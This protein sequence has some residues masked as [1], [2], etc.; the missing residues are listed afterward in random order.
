MYSY[1]TEISN[2]CHNSVFVEIVNHACQ[3][4]LMMYLASINVLVQ[5]ECVQ[6]LNTINN[7][8]TKVVIN[9]PQHSDDWKK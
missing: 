2:I 4:S 1:A 9:I 8:D 5:R 3:S 7:D 6:L